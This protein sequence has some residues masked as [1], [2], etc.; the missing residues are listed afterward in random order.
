M[1]VNPPSTPPAPPVQ[2]PVGAAH[3]VGAAATLL[4]VDEAAVTA[5]AAEGR[6][7]AVTDP[8]SGRPVLPVWQFAEG[9]IRADLAPLIDAWT[10]LPRWRAC[11]WF[12]T[13]AD[14][15]GGWNPLAWLD[16]VASG[17]EGHENGLLAVTRECLRAVTEARALTTPEPDATLVWLLRDPADPDTV[18][19]YA[20]E[21][22]AWTDAYVLDPRAGEHPDRVR[23]ERVTALAAP[24]LVAS[25]GRPPN[26][27]VVDDGKDT[28]S[29]E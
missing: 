18:A 10:G 28:F 24:R 4:G 21:D 27:T 22:A 2:T 9:G 26:L 13:P 20:S 1:P 12:V 29:E 8:Q 17:E 6:L 25:T 14:A 11:R 5:L 15:L 19:V 16:R 7:L 3:T 23:P